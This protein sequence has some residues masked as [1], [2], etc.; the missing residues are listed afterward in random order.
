M[1]ITCT[2]GHPEAIAAAGF[3]VAFRLGALNDSVG[4][5]K[6]AF[7]PYRVMNRTS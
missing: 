6:R 1:T 7:P 3:D 2:S 5:E 4:M